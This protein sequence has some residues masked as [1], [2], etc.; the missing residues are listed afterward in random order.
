M[1][2][3]GKLPLPFK[4]TTAVTVTGRRVTIKGPKATLEREL[5]ALVDVA[6]ADGVVQVTRQDDSRA[7]RARHGLVRNLIRNMLAGVETGFKKELEIRGV[8]Y[9]G[10]VKGQ[11][12]NLSLGFSHPVT[13]PIP[14]GIAIAVDKNNIITVT[15]ADKE[16]VGQVAAE[17]RAFRPPEVY[18]GKGIRYL[19][20]RV[21]QKAGK[22]V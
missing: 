21:I 11:N 2:R 17:I 9:R 18:K 13:Y 3:V 4:K 15:G 19:G 10:D 1:S 12:L 5:P 7:A 16:R 8:G 14:A 22:T 6:V 20:E